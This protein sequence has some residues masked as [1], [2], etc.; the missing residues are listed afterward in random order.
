M[1]TLSF[2]TS[3]PQT[4]T[5]VGIDDIEVQKYLDSYFEQFHHRWPIIHRPSHEEE[6][7][8]ADLCVLSMKMIGGW[9]LGTTESIQFAS[10][11]HNVLAEHIT[12]E[13]VRRTPRIVLL[14]DSVIASC[15]FA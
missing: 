1:L 5:E 12:S 15:H 3:G 13:L 10:E 7:K 8:E 14:S 4:A 9:I 2:Q 11:T 6:V